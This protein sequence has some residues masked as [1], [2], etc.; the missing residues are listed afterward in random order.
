LDSP[1]NGRGGWL[2]VA[3]L[4]ALG[5]LVVTMVFNTLGVRQGV[6]QTRQQ[7]QQARETALH[8]EIGMLTSLSAYLQQVDVALTLTGAE[9]HLHNP[10]VSLTQREAS[11]VLAQLQSYDYLAWLF[12]QKEV[13]KLSSATLYWKPRMLHALDIANSVYSPPAVARHFPE[14]VHFARAGAR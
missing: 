2:N 6:D 10:K 11:K 13:W 12:N 3:T 14:L 5:T 7:A 8:T 4:L 9:E 1:G